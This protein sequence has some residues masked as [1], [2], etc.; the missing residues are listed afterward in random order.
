MVESDIL[1]DSLF[2]LISFLIIVSR[3]QELCRDEAI[4]SEKFEKLGTS[5]R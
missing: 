1:G 2:F 3:D 4:S 5:K